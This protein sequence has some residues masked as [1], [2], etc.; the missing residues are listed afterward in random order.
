MYPYAWLVVA[1]RNNI[2]IITV[3]GL[4]ASPL[5]SECLLSSPLINTE[6]SLAILLGLHAYYQ[7]RSTSLSVDERQYSHWLHSE[8]FAGGLQ[9]LHAQNPYE[10]EKG[11]S[12]T[13]TSCATTP[14]QRC[15]EYRNIVR[16]FCCPEIFVQ[17]CRIWG[18][19]KHFGENLGQN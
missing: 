18:G 11:E 16:K 12:R 2:V 10:E 9:V 4:K 8:F 5:T 14:G 13:P 3:C 6:R 15:V 19:E 7:L 17:K 1:H